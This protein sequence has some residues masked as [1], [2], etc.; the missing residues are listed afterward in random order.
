MKYR[1][2]RGA[3]ALIAAAFLAPAA[4]ADLPLG[5]KA[6]AFVTQGAQGGKAFAFNLRAALRK[7]PVV[8][9]FY[10]KSFTQGCTLEAHAFADA[11]DD[12]RAAGATVIGLSADDL[13]TQKKFS[14]EHCRDKFPVGIATPA[15]A[16]A[17]D[18]TLKGAG[19][20]AGMTART[21]Y[22]IGR[23]GRIKLAYTNM[24]FR[25]HVRMTLAAV[26]SLSGN[27]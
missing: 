20:P 24:D 1:I 7:G 11:M 17:Y 25:D 3:A 8:L 10:P 5:A 14:T 13:A 22:V 12:F 18:V 16:T 2:L 21:S 26:R 4:S 6:P 9:Y 19:A 23:D 27:R 15:I